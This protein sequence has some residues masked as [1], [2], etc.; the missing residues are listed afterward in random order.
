VEIVFDLGK[1]ISE[2]ILELNF[3]GIIF[4]V[5]YTIFVIYYLNLWKLFLIWE[6]IFQKKNLTKFKW[7]YFSCAIQ[8]LCYL[9]FNVYG[10]WV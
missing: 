9:L 5:Q 7:Y 4:R 3:S 6:K 1:N 10:I 2:K 8:N